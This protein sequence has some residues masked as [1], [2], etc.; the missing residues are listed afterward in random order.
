MEYLR[1]F[2]DKNKL[3][4]S[5]LNEVKSELDNMKEHDSKGLNKAGIVNLD[6]FL[7]SVLKIY[8]VILHKNKNFIINLFKS[9]DI[10]NSQSLGC[11]EFI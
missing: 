3:N 5:E 7:V 10:N 1:I 2:A 6:Q 11:Y 9:V 8:R 4:P